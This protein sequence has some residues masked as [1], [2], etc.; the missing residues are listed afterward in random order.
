MSACIPSVPYQPISTDY[1][2]LP[3]VHVAVGTTSQSKVSNFSIVP[4][5]ED[6][7]IQAAVFVFSRVSSY[8]CRTKA[9]GR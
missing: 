4:S 5:F 2:S 8:N 1:H 6:H 3:L 7:H 9:N